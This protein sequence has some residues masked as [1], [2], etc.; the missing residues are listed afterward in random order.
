METRLMMGEIHSEWVAIFPAQ[1]E[2]SLDW[3]QMMES[4]LAANIA[5]AHE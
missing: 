4:S 1:P 2:V 3:D 5:N